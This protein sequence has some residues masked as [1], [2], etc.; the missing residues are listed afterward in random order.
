[1]LHMLR[2]LSFYLF[3]IITSR[4]R[5]PNAN[6]LIMS[7]FF[8]L[9][10]RKDKI[11]FFFRGL[12]SSDHSK[13]L[14][15]HK[16][17]IRLWCGGGPTWRW[18]FNCPPPPS[19]TPPPSPPQSRPPRPTFPT[20]RGRSLHQ[21]LPYPGP[22]SC[23]EVLIKISGILPP[24]KEFYARTISTFPPYG[25]SEHNWTP[26]QVRGQSYGLVVPSLLVSDTLASTPKTLIYLKRWIEMVLVKGY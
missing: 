2:A 5:V 17:P 14:P 7:A 13:G 26:A 10:R 3:I 1:M 12:F 18:E 11:S 23:C 20:F 19:Q 24:W 21:R 4:G 16:G 15:H 9:L 6:V 22:S 8:C 25:G